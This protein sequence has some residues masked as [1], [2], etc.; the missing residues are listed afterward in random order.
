M[1]QINKDITT[2]QFDPDKVQ[3]IYD[4]LINIF[5]CYKPTVFEIL[6]AY[7]NLGYSLGASIEGFKDKGP[8]IEEL[9]ELYYKNPTLGVALMCQAVEVMGW[10]ETYQ[11]NQVKKEDT[12]V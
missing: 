1:T 12:K 8:P 9:Q 4:E 11:K 3:H 2:L 5:K 7:S 10:G 6:T